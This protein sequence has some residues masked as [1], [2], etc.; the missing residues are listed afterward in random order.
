MGQI[1]CFR[2][3]TGV[4]DYDIGH[5]TPE[6]MKDLVAYRMGHFRPGNGSKLFSIKIVLRDF[7]V[8]GNIADLQKTV[9]SRP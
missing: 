6:R 9:D 4:G 3:Q 2:R 7:S 8:S 5:Q 1:D